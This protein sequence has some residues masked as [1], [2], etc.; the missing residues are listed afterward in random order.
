M[1]DAVIGASNEIIGGIVVAAMFGLLGWVYKRYKAF[2]KEY[3]RT[4]QEIERMK[5]ETSQLRATKEE[6]ERLTAEIQRK[7]EELRRVNAN[8]HD[9]SLRIKKLWKQINDAEA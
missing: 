6:H 8:S 1:W 2:K 9:D 5:E 3:A 7:D 4:K